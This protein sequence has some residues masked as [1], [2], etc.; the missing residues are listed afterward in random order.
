M[1][2]LSLVGAAPNAH[3]KLH[4]PE[5]RILLN[6][7][8]PDACNITCSSWKSVQAQIDQLVASNLALAAQ[9]QQMNATIQVLESGR[10]SFALRPLTL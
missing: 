8:K 9:V 5:S 1:P 3:L 4:G 7:D 10:S 6:V 2:L